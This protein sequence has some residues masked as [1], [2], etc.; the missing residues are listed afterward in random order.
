MHCQSK[1]WCGRC[2]LVGCCSTTR[3][4]VHCCSWWCAC[5]RTSSTSCSSS[6]ARCSVLRPPSSPLQRRAGRRWLGRV[7]GPRGGRAGHVGGAFE[8]LLGSDNM[9][10]RAR[11]CGRTRAQRPARRSTRA[12]PSPPTRRRRRGRPPAGPPAYSLCGRV[13]GLHT[14]GQPLGHKPETASR[15][16]SRETALWKPK[17]PHV[18]RNR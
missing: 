8:I 7:R 12:L 5:A 4:R 1:S 10:G 11:A 9:V 2:R 15:I 17:P 13:G 16:R 3:T 14:R 6:P 18:I